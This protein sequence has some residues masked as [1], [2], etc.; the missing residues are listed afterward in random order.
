M[1]GS[2]VHKIAQEAGVDLCGIAPVDRFDLAP[3]G[4][5][6]KDILPDCHS[7]IVLA[8]RFPADD[9]YKYWDPDNSHGRGILYLR[10]AASAWKKCPAKALDGHTIDQE[11]CRHHSIAFTGKGYAVYN[12]RICRNICPLGTGKNRRG[13]EEKKNG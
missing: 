10:H 6:P 7:V 11:K 4:F 8:R 9:P 12:C 5:N 2:G 13:E 1:T 3:R